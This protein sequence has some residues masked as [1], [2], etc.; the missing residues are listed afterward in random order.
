MKP[1]IYEQVISEKIKE[2]LDCIENK[3]KQISK[4]DKEEAP[5]I[6]SAYVAKLIKCGLEVLN[7]DNKKIEPQVEFI[8]KIVKVISDEIE[9]ININEKVL[10]EAEQLQAILSEKSLLASLNENAKNMVRPETSIAIGSLFTGAIKEP[11]MYSELKKEI[12]SSDRIDILVSFIKWSG[13]RL[14]YDELKAFTDEGGT[15]RIITTSYMGATDPKAIEKL[16]KLANTE[17]KISY[18]TKRTR[19]HAKAYVF[20]RNTGY[21]TAYIGSSN[22]SNSAMTSGLEWNIKITKQ[23][24]SEIM[25]KVQATFESY[26]N[27]NEFETYTDDKREKLEIAL[28]KEKNYQNGIVKQNYI[29]DIT[30]YPYQ[31]EILDKLEAERRIRNYYKN[32]VVAATGTGKTVISAFDYKRFCEQNGGDKKRLLFIAHRQEIL[33]QSI[34][35][36]REILKDANFG[37]LFVGKRR[38]DQIDHLFISIDMLNSREW[39]N[40]TSADFYD[41]IILDECHH[42]P[43]KSYCKLLEY[44][45]P[46]IFLGLTATPERMDGKVYDILSYFNN[47][48][49]AEIR[50]PEAIDRKLLCPFQYFGVTD[51]VNLQGLKWTKGG[52]EKSQLENL[53]VFSR[54]IAS[55]RASLV[56]NSL[57]NYVTDI[58]EVKGLGFCVSVEHAK[59]MAETFNNAG[60]SAIYLIGTSDDEF[61]SNAKASLISGEIKIVFVVDIYNEGVD[62]KE[63]NTILFLR[64]TESLTIFLQQL[65]RGLRLADKKECL[66]VLDFVGQANN[67]YNF[68]SKFAALLQ[69]SNRGVKN[70]I[71]NGFTDLPKGCY[72]KL[73]KVAKE[74]ILANIKDSVS[75]KIGLLK[76]IATFEEDTGKQLTLT[77]FISYYKMQPRIIYSNKFTFSE[78][79]D[80]ACNKQVVIEDAEAWKKMYRL[81]TIDSRNFLKYMIENLESYEVIDYSKLNLIE[82]GYWKMLYMSIYDK[83]LDIKKT[84]SYIEALAVYF[85][86]NNRVFKEIIELFM[87][88]YDS[89]DFVD[90]ETQLPYICPLDIN[91]TYTRAQLLAGVDYWNTSSEGVAYVKEKKT[92]MLFVTLNKT[93]SYYSPTTTYHDYS[94]NEHLFHWQSQNSTSEYTSVGKRY[95][96]HKKLGEVILLFVREYKEDKY[97]AIPFTFLGPVSYNCHIENKPMSITWKLENAIPAR[98]IKKTDKLG[99]S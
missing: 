85:K 28:R 26:W 68:G 56:I 94:I 71:L 62:L 4:I 22:M 64:P 19:L 32:L 72:I 83:P 78:A 5:Y 9:D 37:D 40:N 23:D 76:R 17:I 20:Y 12:L 3:Y 82:L 88:N 79:I 98:F 99:V 11:N 50:L 97:G 10:N 35:C 53:Y 51:C 39:Y 7:E 55:K 21:S 31:Q 65:G 81:A 66:T 96:N 8:N 25:K 61:R 75:G 33:V 48:I 95:I 73:E 6:L 57:I 60:I 58:N 92:T 52:Y 14:I 16:K 69:T 1:G 49:A 43:A 47:R 36:F 84:N 41:Y 63:I 80:M 90:I 2:Q 38:P 15:L 18:D 89:I 45:T 44:Y 27:S 24:M 46:K 34:E 91:C 42:M 93:N 13:L 74:R 54:G 87:C 29:F 86:N 67:K 59:F 30:P 77:D 70:E